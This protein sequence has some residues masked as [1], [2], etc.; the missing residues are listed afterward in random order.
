MT[1]IQ[2][3]ISKSKKSI[4]QMTRELAPYMGIEWNDAWYQHIYRVVK[5]E[6]DPTPEEASAINAW[7][8]SHDNPHKAGAK[9][10]R[11]S[12]LDRTIDILQRNMRSGVHNPTQTSSM[13][14][15]I[16]SAL[17]D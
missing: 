17:R 16:F 7:A 1:E 2:D 4:K 10:H 15:K 9:V 5:G 11:M 6:V 12:G 3:R 13:F 8:D 14:K